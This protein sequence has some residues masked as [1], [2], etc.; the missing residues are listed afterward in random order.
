MVTSTAASLPSVVGDAALTVD[1]LD[2]EGLTNAVAAVLTD[3]TL[4]QGLIERGLARSRTFTWRSAAQR[5]L[6]IYEKVFSTRF[7]AT[8]HV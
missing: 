4:R 2:E 7:G 8:L 6:L 5:T 3:P 1:P